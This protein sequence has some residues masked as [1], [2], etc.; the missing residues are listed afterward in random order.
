LQARIVADEQQFAAEA[1]N[2]RIAKKVL[3]FTW[4]LGNMA[5]ANIHPVVSLVTTVVY[6]LRIKSWVILNVVGKQ[7]QVFIEQRTGV[8]Q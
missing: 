1:I 6:R 3:C 5:P 2:C 8:G 4:F 7:E